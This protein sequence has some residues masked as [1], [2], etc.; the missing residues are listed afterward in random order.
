MAHVLF[1]GGTGA[2]GVPSIRLFLASGSQA[3]IVARS[4]HTPAKLAGL[5]KGRVQVVHGDVTKPNCGIDR[6]TIT[7]LTGR[8]DVVVHCA[9]KTQYYNELHD[10]TME[11]NVKGT[12]HV[13]E[14]AADLEI[15]K[16]V[17]VSTAYV[18][19]RRPR[20]MENDIARIEDT[21][22]P[23]EKSK[24]IA[25]GLVRL[26]PG[27]HLIARLSTVIGD[28]ITGELQDIGGFAGFVRSLYTLRKRYERYAGHPFHVGINPK[29]TL[30]LAPR[31]WVVDM[32]LKATLSGMTGVVHLC[33][34][35][36]VPMGWLFEETFKKY[37]KYPLTFE[38][39]VADINALSETD[40]TWKSTQ[41]GI[42]Q[43]IVGYFKHYVE[44]DTVFDH[45]RVREI[46]GYWA[47]PPITAEVIKAQ[48]DYM[49]RHLFNKAVRESERQ[50]A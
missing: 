36:P 43:N 25:E 3:T 45:T 12:E 5:F 38:K 34:T 18:A 40:P 41:E 46:P 20:L 44:S 16:V 24:A 27:D 22:N 26:Y 8:F 50:V 2:I 1:T 7:D 35:D 17:Y 37:F 30:N 29:S 28:S 23:Y 47:P 9:G 6:D 48:L 10:D 19:G 33:H 13:L 14:L 42:A 31:E 15:P 4:K 39:A 11:A 49:V 32:L 21:R